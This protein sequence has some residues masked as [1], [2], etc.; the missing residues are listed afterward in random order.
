VRCLAIRV[1]VAVLWFAAAP[2]PAEET[3]WLALERPTEEQRLRLSAPLVEVRGRTLIGEPDESG[4]AVG[5][6]ELVS[7]DVVL[8]LD[9]SNTSLL[10]MGVDVDGD[11]KV[12]RDRRT[13][14][15]RP[16]R[17]HRFWTTDPD[18]TIIRSELLAARVLVDRLGERRARLGVLTYTGKPRA[19]AEV[20]S[21]ERAIEE[22][23][24]IRVTVDWTG[25]DISRAL[26]LARDMLLDAPRKRGPSRP[27]IVLLFSD[28]KPTVPRNEYVAGRR[29]LRAAEEL[30][31][32]GVQVY[33]LAFGEDAREDPGVLQEIADITGGR[34]VEVED[35]E[36]VLEELAKVE[37]V[38]P[39]GL[40]I[41][42][43]TTEQL[44][45]AVRVF[46]DGSF[47]G[48]VP[49]APGWNRLEV[50]A[51]G[52][53][54]K[55]VGVERRVFYEKPEVESLE[56]RRRAAR[57]LVELRHRAAETELASQTEPELRRE[58]DV[59]I[60]PEPPA[61]RVPDD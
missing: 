23:E 48:F 12:G 19:R 44:A 1:S 25:T 61:G 6:Q 26:R 20:G 16:R 46:V 22:L 49:L 53:D 43:L 18:D 24:R 21:R 51:L 14:Y 35:P 47:D 8:A 50:S 57:M 11:G 52:P 39:A 9:L 10:A 40:L 59:E 30:S 42:N 7:A 60:Y 37:F 29:A 58:S 38:K 17:S 31:E 36:R 33:T 45:R 32:E 15:G 34:F 3:L 28:G 2:A 56:D 41:R 27:R 55:R 13:V 4:S 5:I 54:G